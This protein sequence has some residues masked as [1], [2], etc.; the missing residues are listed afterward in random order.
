[1]ETPNVEIPNVEIPNVEI[2]NVEI[3]NVFQFMLLN[4]K[5]AKN[6]DFRNNL[7]KILEIEKEVD[8]IFNNIGEKLVKVAK[9]G[10]NHLLVWSNE[11][12]F[13]EFKNLKFSSLSKKNGFE[14]S[15]FGK[16][17]GRKHFPIIN[18]TGEY[19]VKHYGG[20]YFDKNPLNVQKF[21]E[22]EPKQ[23]LVHNDSYG[24]LDNSFNSRIRRNIIPPP[25]KYHLH[26]FSNIKKNFTND[27]L[28]K[29]KDWKKVE[30]LKLHIELRMEGYKELSSY[31]CKR[32]CGFKEILIE[33]K[34]KYNHFQNPNPLK[35]S[36]RSPE[37]YYLELRILPKEQFFK[38]I[39][40]KE[41]HDY[42]DHQIKFL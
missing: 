18:P 37:N 25:P 26:N 14:K 31:V 9:E 5:S 41:F 36:P 3:P 19:A 30:K 35:E 21:F 23:S 6:Y 40:I 16:E 20:R 4:L 2:P 38:M 32:Y 28:V 27:I 42:Y 11:N 33:D 7:K 34:K 10:E 17:Y 24:L 12:Q 8:Q 22:W 1:M 15:T 39:D 13:D 29:T